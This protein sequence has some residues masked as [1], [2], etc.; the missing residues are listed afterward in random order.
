M[1]AKVKNYLKLLGRRIDRIVLDNEEEP[2]GQDSMYFV[3]YDLFFSFLIA[4]LST[5]AIS[6]SCKFKK[7]KNL[8]THFR[9]ARGWY[10]YGI[11][12]RALDFVGF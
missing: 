3:L 4:F 12:F 1:L 2:H 9:R 6:L 11:Q 10:M 8:N 7:K 5:V